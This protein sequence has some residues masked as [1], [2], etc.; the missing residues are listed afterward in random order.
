MEEL[1]LNDVEAVNGG[2]FWG[3]ALAVA[4]TPVSAPVAFAVIGFSL[5]A[6]VVGGAYYYTR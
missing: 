2:G 1:S 6:A 3:V 4:L 5:G